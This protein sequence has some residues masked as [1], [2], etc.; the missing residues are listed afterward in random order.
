MS[1]GFNRYVVDFLQWVHDV[2]W[3][4]EGERKIAPYEKIGKS[5]R[6]VD[7]YLQKIERN[8][9][10]GIPNRDVAAW[11]FMP[12]RTG[13]K[14]GDQV[15]WYILCLRAGKK[16]R[17][18]V[19]VERGRS[20]RQTSSINN[21][22]ILVFRSSHWLTRWEDYSSDE[23]FSVD[24]TFHHDESAADL[25]DQLAMMLKTIPINEINWHFEV[26]SLRKIQAI[27]GG[28]R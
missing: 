11:L 21:Y 2:L 3:Y 15:D 23:V 13:V 12:F 24:L 6:S 25:T 4:R 16:Q 1:H 18:R 7:G 9:P 14:R 17:S 28:E 19:Y 10:R 20:R 27:E 5:I 26:E 8:I 22:K